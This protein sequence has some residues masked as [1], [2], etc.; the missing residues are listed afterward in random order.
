MHELQ[1]FVAVV[2]A[3][4]Y[5]AAARNTGQRK[6][7]LSERVLSLE[8]RLGVKLL[9]RTT[10]ALRLTDE[11]H[12]YLEH[13][14]R[15]LIAIQ[16]AEA[17]VAQS[18]AAPAGRL[19]VT[20]PSHLAAE[21]LQPV[22]LPYLQEF[23]EVSLDLDTSKRVMDLV[24]DGFDLAL[25]VGALPDSSMI[26]RRLGLSHGGYFASPSYLGRR[27]PHVPDDLI[28][29][30]LIAM[31]REDGP[32]EWPFVVA[33]RPRVLSIRKPRLLVGTFDIAVDAAVAGLGV[34]RAPLRYVQPHIAGGSLV[35]ILAKS[36][37]PPFSVH[38]LFPPGAGLVP[39]ARV[40]IDRV[41]AWYATDGK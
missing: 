36:N 37:P 3:A 10:R 22:I 33:G 4:G 11:G 5:T 28:G 25:R 2:D 26:A 20:M 14:R 29:H 9:V 30:S 19:R 24:S 39:R 38:A 12:A 16:D 23:S 13:A 7:T 40:F 32:V 35:P 18:R 41:A 21:L 15:A 8:S 1:A 34:V 17:A 31:A 6:A 27:Q